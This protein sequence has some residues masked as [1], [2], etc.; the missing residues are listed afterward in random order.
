MVRSRVRSAFTLIELLVVIAIIAVLIGLLLPAVQKVREAAAMAKCQ[1]NLKQLALACHNY[2]DATGNLPANY[3]CCGT[4]SGHWSWIA[5]ILPYIEQTN[6]YQAGNIGARNA[7]GYPTTTLAASTVGGQPTITYPIPMVR[8]PSDPAGGQILWTDRADIGGGPNGQGCAISN[9]KSVAGANWEWGI[10]LWNPGWA[11][12]SGVNGTSQQGLDAGN[13]VIWRSNGPGASGNIA[14][15]V[16]YSWR[17]SAITD[18]TSNTFMIGEDLPHLS[19]WCGC[20][21]YANNTTG[22]VAIYLNANQTAGKGGTLENDTNGDWGDNYG[23]ASAHTG[24]ANFAFCD[25]HVAFISNGINMTTTYRWL[26]T[27]TGGEVVA[28]P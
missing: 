10:A 2:H 5:M 15:G 23:F 18:G 8:C 21:A 28:V 22:T 4:G 19:Q 27:A 1:N 13:G 11:P 20:W 25:A 9:Y 16:E 6:L 24:G 7:I 12:G 14:G 26:G 3:G 17:L